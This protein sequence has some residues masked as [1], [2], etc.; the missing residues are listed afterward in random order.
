MNEFILNILS[1]KSIKAKDKTPILGKMILDDSSMIDT[2]VSIAQNSK[3]PIKGTLIEAMEYAT[4]Q[5][6]EVVNTNCFHFIIEH[7]ESKAPRVKWES[8]KVIGNTARLFPKLLPEAV[9]KLIVN[10]NHEG[11]V[12]RWSAA[13]A[14][15][16]IL[17]TKSGLNKDLIP[18]VQNICERE[19]KDSIKKIYLKALKSIGA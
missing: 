3:D 5:Q 6:P 9:E 17:K 8:A 19:E 7:L 14:L 12:V 15:S 10:T 11:T 4:Q 16:E 2:M 13:F 1:D 18:T